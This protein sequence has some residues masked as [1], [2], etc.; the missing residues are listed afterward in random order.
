MDYTVL[1]NAALWALAVGFVSPPVIALIQQRTWSPRVKALIAFGFA[2]I[3]AAVTAYF[4]GLFTVPDIGRLG[5][6]IFLSAVAS[7]QGFWKPTGVAPAIEK[8]TSVSSGPEGGVPD[9]A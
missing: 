5:L 2:L 1:D 9:D 4:N 7:Y 6:L 8:A 3:V